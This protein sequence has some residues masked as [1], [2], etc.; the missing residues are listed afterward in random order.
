M[1]GGAVGRGRGRS[2]LVR[3][4]SVSALLNLYAEILE[5]LRDR[6]VV[7]SANSPVGDYAEHL[8]ATAFNWT[9]VANSAAG[10]DAVDGKTRY[11]IKARRLHSHN[12]SRQLSFI[13]RLPERNFH[14]LAGVLF[15]ED[16][17]VLRAALIPHAL[18]AGNCRFSTH[19]NGWLFMLEDNVWDWSGVKDVTTKLKAAAKRIG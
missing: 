10:Y 13:R 19:A 5:E 17:T 4:R 18:L 2:Q 16:Y 7:R 12:R 8:F 9:L 11:Q 3:K 6:G 14:Y 1:A 15:N